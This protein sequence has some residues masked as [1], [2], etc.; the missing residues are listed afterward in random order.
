MLCKLIVGMVM[1]INLKASSCLASESN[2]AVFDLELMMDF[3]QDCIYALLFN[4][5]DIIKEES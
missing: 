2:N 1:M 4:K 3:N 5:K